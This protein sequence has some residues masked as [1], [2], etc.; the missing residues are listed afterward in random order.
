VCT[1]LDDA[2]I[3]VSGSQDRVVRV[4]DLRAKIADYE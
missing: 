3:A 4:W 2:L 1:I